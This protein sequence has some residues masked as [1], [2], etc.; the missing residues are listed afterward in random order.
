MT[1]RWPHPRIAFA[2][3]GALVHAV[4]RPRFYTMH[5]LITNNPSTGW[6]YLFRPSIILRYRASM[7]SRTGCG[8]GRG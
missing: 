2:V 3:L 7:S 4:K 5:P 6:S 8:S 1:V